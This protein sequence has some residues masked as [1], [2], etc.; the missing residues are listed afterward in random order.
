NDVQKVPAGSTNWSISNYL[1][2]TNNPNDLRIK[3]VDSAGNHS[4]EVTI[5]L[6]RDNYAPVL[7]GITPTGATNTVP[8]VIGIGYTESETDVDLA[9]SSVLLYRN[10]VS[11]PGTLQKNASTLSFVPAS[12]LIQGNYTLDVSLADKA[13]NIANGSYNLVIDTTPPPAPVVDTLPA[14]TTDAVIQISVQKATGSGI[15]AQGNDVVAV[16]TGIIRRC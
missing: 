2:S 16:R 6:I 9:A 15:R 12:T 4:A 3:A 14:V 11:V 13:G 8:S 5:R 10:G 1:L 7:H